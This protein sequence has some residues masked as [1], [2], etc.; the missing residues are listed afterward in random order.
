MLLAEL[1]HGSLVDSQG[2]G[3][4]VVTHALS[5]HGLGVHP[6][7]LSVHTIPPRV[8]FEMTLEGIV[9]VALVGTLLD[10]HNRCSII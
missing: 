4:L 3:Y 10:D 6:G 2:V 7:V 5:P 1:D 9:S 8:S